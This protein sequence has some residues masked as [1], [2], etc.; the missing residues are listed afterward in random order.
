MGMTSSAKGFDVMSYLGIKVR[1][2]SE[3]LMIG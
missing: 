1:S 3:G 2:F